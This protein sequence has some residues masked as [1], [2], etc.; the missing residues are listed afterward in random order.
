MHSIY[1]KNGLVITTD[2]SALDVDVIHDFLKRSY[3]AKGVPRE[4]VERAIENSLCFGLFEGH[5]QIGFARLV[6]DMTHMAH[7]CDV[8][9]L[10]SHQRQGLGRWLMECVLACPLLDGIRTISL[11][12]ADAHDFYRSL[13]FSEISRPE[14]RMEL[15][16]DIDWFQPEADDPNKSESH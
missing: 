5:V 11:A 13:G 12:T 7:L 9:I 4:R 15:L 16:R 14:K 2:P 3:W 10:E 1:R 8:F 6:T